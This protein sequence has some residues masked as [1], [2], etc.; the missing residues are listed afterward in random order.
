MECVSASFLLLSFFDRYYEQVQRLP[1][2]KAITA[3]MYDQESNTHTRAHAL[4][5]PTA[6]AVQGMLLAAALVGGVQQH[7]LPSPLLAYSETE[8]L[9]EKIK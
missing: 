1:Q 8:I 5:K 4:I 7:T 6:L 2:A 3:K 9:A